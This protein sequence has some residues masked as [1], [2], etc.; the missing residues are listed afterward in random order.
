MEDTSKRPKALEIGMLTW[1]GTTDCNLR[2]FRGW[3]WSGKN[4]QS[5]T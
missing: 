5:F 3:H 1:I 2:Y 4:T